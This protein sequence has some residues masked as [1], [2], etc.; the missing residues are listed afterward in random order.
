M[1]NSKAVCAV[2]V[3]Y[4]RK[5]L[6][7]RCLEHVLKQKYKVRQIIIIDNNSSDNS[8]EYIINYFSD[9]FSSS[10]IKFYWKR[11]E[12][13]LGGAGG[14]SAGVEEFCNT[15]CDF[16]WLMDDD[17]FPDY[18]CLETLIKNSNSRVFIGPIVLSDQDK[19]HLAFPLRLPSSLKVIDKLTDL[20]LDWRSTKLSDVVLPFNGTLISRD[21]VEQIGLPDPKYFIWGDEVDYTERA[22]NVEAE[23]STICEALYFH[24]KSCN[25]GNPMF[26]GVL[27]FND[28][29]NDLKLYCYCRNNVANKKKY[30]GLLQAIMFACK[31]FWYYCFTHPSPLKLKIS[32]V[33]TYHGLINDFTKHLKYSNLKP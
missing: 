23:I 25:L 33:A 12:K 7:K 9:F 22:R 10:D 28:P 20:G 15:E 8:K 29:S 24:P 27:R 1:N 32:I 21:I 17:G 14:F 3:T 13:N 19:I 11:L 6:L 18:H 31:T 5:K 16:V 2:I 4:N 26:F 30:R